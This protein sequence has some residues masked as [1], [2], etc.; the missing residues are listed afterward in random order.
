MPEGGAGE[1]P[2]IRRGLAEVYFDRSRITEIDGRNGELRYRGYAIGELVEQA[3]FEETAW[4]LIHGELPTPGELAGFDAALREARELPAAV[5]DVLRSQTGA[6]PMDALRTAVSA[7]A[8]H[9]PE[10][11]DAG[12]EAVVRKGTRLLAQSAT[13]VAA[14]HALRSGREP[15]RPDAGLAFADNLLFMLR[16]EKPGERDARILE[17]DLILHADHDANAS[18]FTARVVTGAQADLHAAV[19][20][21]LAAFAGPLHGG[22][23]EGVMAMV[24]E[25]GE[26]ERV[27]EYVRARRAR[28]EPIPGFGHRVYRT[29]DPRA[30]PMRAIARELAA[31]TGQQRW[32]AIF[33]ELV[34]AMKP[35]ARHGVDVNVDFYAGAVYRM[36]GIP[37]D[38][39]VP[40]FAVGRVAGWVAQVLEQSERNILIRPRLRYEGSAARP[41]VP[42]AER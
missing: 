23:V 21:A 24:E 3:S 15:A 5:V 40:L 19:T 18:A 39:A 12:R 13:L 33:E 10:R 42:L 17:R 41:F 1:G 32:Y 26:P 4:L 8:A 6:H 9:D 38:L 35:Y 30:A 2:R 29:E 28:R 25:I 37:R 22:A 16:G 7:L 11:A 20:A 36:L 14:H 34:E 27:A 31:R